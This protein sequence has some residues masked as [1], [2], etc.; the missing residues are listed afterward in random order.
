M[1]DSLSS[2]SNWKSVISPNK[3]RQRANSKPKTNTQQ[4]S[5]VKIK[6]MNFGTGTKDKNPEFISPRL[7]KTKKSSQ[8]NQAPSTT[9]GRK[10]KQQVVRDLMDRLLCDSDQRQI[11]MQE[12]ESVCEPS[13]IQVQN[14]FSSRLR[15]LKSKTPV[16]SQK[17]LAFT[18]S[19]GGAH[20]QRRNQRKP[21]A[22]FLKS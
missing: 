22:H 21:P 8:N 2:R 15:P 7:K 5:F 13:F 3:S 20:A 19:L 6:N 17:N 10:S 14:G 4:H 11:R 12:K 18:S 1:R 16:N 9:T